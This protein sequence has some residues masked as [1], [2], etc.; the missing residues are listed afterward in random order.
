MQIYSKIF[1]WNQHQD[2]QGL[3]MTF[4]EHLGWNQTFSLMWCHDKSLWERARGKVDAMANEC[5]VNGW[6]LGSCGWWRRTLD[7]V[8]FFS[9]NSTVRLCELRIK[10]DVRFPSSFT[11]FLRM[12]STIV[13]PG[14]RLG[15]AQDFVAGSGTYERD[16]LL[17]ASV[18]GVKKVVNTD[19]SNVSISCVR[20]RRAMPRLIHL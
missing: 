7:F 10:L 20:R 16:G 18:V 3:F 9:L 14:Q 8:T 11:S 19:N 17:Y 15:Y 1:I 5:R 13:T 4:N 2:T 12:T 6:L